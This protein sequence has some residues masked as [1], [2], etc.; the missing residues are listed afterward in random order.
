MVTMAPLKRG[1]RSCELAQGGCLRHVIATGNDGIE[2][3]QA[4]YHPLTA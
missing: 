4:A 3:L 2:N 1:C